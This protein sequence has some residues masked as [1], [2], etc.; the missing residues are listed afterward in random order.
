MVTVPAWSIKPRSIMPAQVAPVKHDLSALR[1][2]LSQARIRVARAIEAEV[3]ARHEERNEAAHLR[4]VAYELW[5]D[6]EQ[7]YRA[8]L[9]GE[10]RNE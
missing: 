4:V 3:S 2:E 10:W 7:A 8:A 5:W 1:V 9:A 6:V